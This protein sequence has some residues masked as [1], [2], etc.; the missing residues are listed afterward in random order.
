MMI[1]RPLFG[2]AAMIRRTIALAGASL[3]ILGLVPTDLRFDCPGVPSA[4]ADAGGNGKGHN[5]NGK[6]N[7]RQNSGQAKGSQASAA[8]SASAAASASAASSSK[9]EDKGEGK[10]SSK[11]RGRDEQKSE[12][13]D[14]SDAPTDADQSGPARAPAKAAERGGR[15]FVA[16]EVVVANL[17]RKARAGARRLGFAV[18]EE[19]RLESLGL[20]IARLRV[21]RRMTAPAA[22][23]LLARRYPRVLV[24]LNA[25]YRPQG[26]LVLPPLD[27]PGKLIGW[28]QVPDGC[29]GGL[30]IGML[31]TAVDPATPG[32]RD[33]RIIQR[34]FL[35]AGA[36]TASTEHG[37]AIAALLVGRH[38]GGGL[39]PGAEL[40]VAG[41]F[42]ADPDG[43]P[44]ADAVALV[45]GLDWLVGS[46]VPVINMSFAGDANALV[47]LALQRVIAG[48]A[49]VVA[50]A[51]NGGPAA[52]PAFPASEPG[53]IAVT[54]VDSHGQPYAR[55]GHGD[56]VAFA[57]PGVQVWTPGPAAAGSYRTGTSFAVPFVTAAVAAQFAG[58]APPNADLIVHLLAA[59]AIDLGAP[60]KDPVFGRGLIQSV[61]P[62][63]VPTQ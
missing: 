61:N 11:A 4:Q 62:C 16:D 2:I 32:L 52:A 29:G 41:V 59:R 3:L 20:T 1:V 49:I 53:V 10:E 28:G 36:R 31:D 44:I 63:G 6:G 19:R 45:S 60:G 5:G 12:V 43:V 25:L 9:Q 39:L 34:S 37:S 46:R 18:L 23:T 50:A 55:A 15:D 51:G 57:A 13:A 35:P 56:H 42:A 17:D 38:A 58:G 7:G 14:Q 30:R 22:R 33:A 54:A 21:P 47:A 40:A 24:D 27:Y 48:P 8:S 26:Q